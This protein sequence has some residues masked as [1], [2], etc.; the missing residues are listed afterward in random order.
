MSW[1]MESSIQKNMDWIFIRGWN[2]VLCVIWIV[3]FEKRTLRV[4]QVTEAV[5]R[6]FVC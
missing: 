3:D 6:S 2:G 5:A 1:L 4:P